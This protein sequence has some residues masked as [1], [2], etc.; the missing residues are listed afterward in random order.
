MTAGD[1]SSGV[2]AGGRFHRRIWSGGDGDHSE[3]HGYAYQVRDSHYPPLEYGYTFLPGYFWADTLFTFSPGLPQSALD[4]TNNLVNCATNKIQQDLSQ[5]KFH[6][7]VF[8]G[9]FRESYHM[10]CAIVHSIAKAVTLA[11]HGKWDKAMRVLATQ[12][13][14]V[15]PGLGTGV[16]AN[17]YMMWH[18]G[19]LPLLDD[20]KNAY[21]YMKSHYHKLK[22]VRRHCVYKE[23][24]RLEYS[25]VSWQWTLKALVEIRGNVEMVE[26]SSVDRLGLNDLA[27][28]AWEVTKL[29][30]LIDWVLPIGNFLSAVNASNQTK[31][32]E[33]WISR[34]Q[35]ETLS[36]PKALAY[37]YAF[38]GNFSSGYDK[39][40]GPGTQN[41]RTFVDSLPWHFPTIQN[42]LGDNLSRW[43]TA[44]AF[45]RQTVGR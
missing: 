26:L 24:K 20:L 36:D 38:R 9:E 7:G 11:K 34:T 10:I 3:E 14:K 1:V 12:G 29:S 28:V 15:P 13:G 5:N 23:T 22:S 6:A 31:G 45:L 33:F 8:A 30:W 42:P 41:S 37:P 25:G 39:Y 44:A 19:I 4:R 21:E 16:A 27:S 35:S 18:F 40:F 32:T 43:V 2:V 17:N